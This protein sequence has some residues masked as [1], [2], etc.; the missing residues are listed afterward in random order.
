[1]IENESPQSNAHKDTSGSKLCNISYLYETVGGKKHLINQI[2]DAFIKQV[3]E[4]LQTIND[5]IDKSDYEI[6]KIISHTLGSSVSVMGIKVL[7]P[8]LHE[9]E[10][11]GTSASGIERI[12]LLNHELNQICKQAFAEIERERDNYA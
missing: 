9:M 8:V 6:I 3:S 11:L 12:K 2:I 5:A 1:M 4:E 10:D 7:G